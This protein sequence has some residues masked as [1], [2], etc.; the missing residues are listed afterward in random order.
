MVQLDQHSSD[1]AYRCGRL[2][3]VLEEAY[4]LAMPGAKTTIVD[5]FYSIASSAP[6]S[7]F[8]R[9]LSGARSH[10]SKLQRDRPGAH[11]AIQQRVEEILAGLSTFPKMLTIEQQ[12]L[13]SL[14]YYHQRAHDRAQAREAFERRRRNQENQEQNITT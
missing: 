6:A 2:L 12:A 4:R 5:R 9:L 11:Y 7:V 8:S 13:F 3:C 1:P 14:G 10:M